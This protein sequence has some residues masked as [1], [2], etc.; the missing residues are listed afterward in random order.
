M[1]EIDEKDLAIRPEHEAML[2]LGDR[3]DEEKNAIM[4]KILP[5]S[6]AARGA[7]K[8]AEALERN[9]FAFDAAASRVYAAER[10]AR[11]AAVYREHGF[12]GVADSYDQNAKQLRA[13][14][15]YLR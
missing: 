9:G 4:A 7:L 12:V 3:L 1:Q 11:I 5:L 10:Y 13:K 2:V 15:G 8:T 6:E 14:K